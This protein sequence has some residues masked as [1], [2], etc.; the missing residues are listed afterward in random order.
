MRAEASQSSRSERF[1]LFVVIDCTMCDAC[2]L[3]WLIA[4]DN[5]GSMSIYERNVCET[6]ALVME[7]LRKMEC[8][9]AVRCLF[10]YL[11]LFRVLVFCFATAPA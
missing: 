6:L 1:P 9:F 8:R 11:Q 5:S 2:Q 3:E 7:F 4:L 10:I